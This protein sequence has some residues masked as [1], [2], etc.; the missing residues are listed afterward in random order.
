MKSDMSFLKEEEWGNMQRAWDA[1]KDTHE[2]LCGIRK[3]W[4]SNC[5]CKLIAQVR[6]QIAQEIEEATE[7]I[8]DRCKCGAP[9]LIFMDGKDT[10]FANI[11]RGQK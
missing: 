2:E 10:V 4:D 11:A 6:E 7:A 8:E 1:Q 3:G 5:N 9:F